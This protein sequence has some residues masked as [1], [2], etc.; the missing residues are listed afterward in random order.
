MYGNHNATD[1]FPTLLEQ[2]FIALGLKTSADPVTKGEHPRCNLERHMYD[3]ACSINRLRNK[4]GTGHGHPFMPDIGNNEARASIQLI[5]IISER[6]LK[7]LENKA[8]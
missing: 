6:L 3:L 5:G 7:E 2:A 8:K 1:N 4:Q